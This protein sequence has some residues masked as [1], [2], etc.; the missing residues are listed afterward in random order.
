MFTRVRWI[1]TIEKMVMQSVTH[2]VACG[3]GKVLAG[4]V[5][6]IAPDATGL[7][8]VDKASFDTAL[9]QLRW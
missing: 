7:S 1:Q 9:A 3:R 2:I 6:R 5:K 8:L 4:M